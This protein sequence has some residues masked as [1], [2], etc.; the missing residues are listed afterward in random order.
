MEEFFEKAVS[1]ST[2]ISL[3]GLFGFILLYI[4]KKII[5]LDIFPELTRIASR[6]ILILIIN[7]LYVLTFVSMILG[8][9]G[10]IYSLNYTM[11]EKSDKQ[12]KLPIS[13]S[14]FQ[15]L[16]FSS[17][18]ELRRNFEFSEELREYINQKITFKPVGSIRAENTLLLLS[19][20]YEE[21]TVYSYGEEKY[22][23]QLALLLQ[24]VGEKLSL[25]SEKNDFMEWNDTSK[26]TI[27]D[28]LFLCGFLNWYIGTVAVENLN[29]KLSHSLGWNASSDYFVENREISNLNMRYFVFEGRQITEYSEYLGLID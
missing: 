4:S 23:F 6:D 21:A 8:F 2:P 16:L 5:E 9:V 15:N 24:D 12:T 11:L 28:V 14:E 19:S 26:M 7:R 27:D 17:A 29:E 3:A 13:Y 18:Q 20:Y 25:M 10:Y 22:I 1:I